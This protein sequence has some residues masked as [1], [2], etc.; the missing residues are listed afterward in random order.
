M[1]TWLRCL[2]A[3]L[4]L[5]FCATPPAGAAE[6]DPSGGQLVSLGAIAL[7]WSSQY[8]EQKW[9]AM[10]MMD[11]QSDLGWSS[12]EHAPLPHWSV[13]E[14]PEPAEVNALEVWNAPREQQSRHP[15]ISVK[16]L[17]V[18]VSTEGAE[19]GYELLGVF[20]LATEETPQRFPVT[21][22]L[23]RWVKLTVAENHGHPGYTELMDVRLYGSFVE[24]SPGRPDLT[25]TWE[26]R[27]D[28]S[29]GRSTAYLTQR[30]DQVTGC[31]DWRGGR[32]AG[33]IDRRVITYRWTQT[34]GDG[35]VTMVVNREGTRMN[36]FWTLSGQGN[37][38]WWMATKRSNEPERSCGE[39]SFLEDELRKRG[40][41]T[42]YGIHFDFDSARIRPDSH[43]VLKSVAQLLLRDSGL[44]LEIV[45][46]TDDVGPEAYNLALSRQRATSVVQYLVSNWKLGPRRFS[47]NGKGEGEPVVSNDTELG[48]AANRRVELV[49]LSH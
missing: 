18:H 33:G 24:E 44:R 1:I 11:G 45:G 3:T 42:V 40:R 22:R 23:A 26:T 6:Q 38:G 14:L 49:R 47:A 7:Q 16:R 46:H 13:F 19:S 39:G 48:R 35:L 36:G 28:Y 25:G 30:G 37:Q 5:A 32:L 8:G 27:W 31:Y 10:G 15:G 9:S 21:P 20:S 12:A 34:S 2:G 43:P 41:A 29:S 4:L 17:A